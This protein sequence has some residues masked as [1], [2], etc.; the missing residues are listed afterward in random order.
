MWLF[1]NEPRGVGFTIAI[2]KV[3]D[4]G[5][6]HRSYCASHDV[7]IQGRVSTLYFFYW[8][9]LCELIEGNDFFSFGAVM[10]NQT[11]WKLHSP[12]FTYTN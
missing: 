3:V 6:L 4:P 2:E 12:M 7:S 8:A 1:T 10:R 11:V 5:T 9:L